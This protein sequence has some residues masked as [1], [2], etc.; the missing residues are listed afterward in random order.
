MQLGAEGRGRQVTLH[1]PPRSWTGVTKV[2]KRSPT[3]RSSNWSY[4]MSPGM[5]SFLDALLSRFWV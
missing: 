2:Q 3:R 5:P 4:T 1:P